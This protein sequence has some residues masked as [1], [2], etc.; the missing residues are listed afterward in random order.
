[1]TSEPGQIYISVRPKGQASVPLFKV[2]H[3]EVLLSNVNFVN[4]IVL[5]QPR[6]QRE[7]G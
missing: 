7:K 6:Q 2:E 1:M 4:A 5:V 3:E